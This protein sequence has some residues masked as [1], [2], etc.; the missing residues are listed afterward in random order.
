MHLGRTLGKAALWLL[1]LCAVVLAAWFGINATDEALS[2]EA[3]AALAVPLGQAHP[4][5]F[6]GKPMRFDPQTGTIGFDIETEHLSGGARPIRER[7]G[8]MALPL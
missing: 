1:G 6:T 5:P 7:Y 4:D 8:R 2:A 3:R